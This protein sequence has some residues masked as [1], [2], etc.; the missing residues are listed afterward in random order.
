LTVSCSHPRELNKYP[1]FL[2]ANAKIT[3]EKCH[4]AQQENEDWQC[5]GRKDQEEELVLWLMR[6]ALLPEMPALMRTLWTC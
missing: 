3:Y 5:E 4:S 6:K 1:S 2:F